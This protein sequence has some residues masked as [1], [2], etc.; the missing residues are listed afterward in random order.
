M[1]K[2]RMT[3][4]GHAIWMSV[5]GIWFAVAYNSLLLSFFGG[6]LIGYGL[7]LAYEAGQES[8]L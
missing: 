4:Y 2:V 8:K 5:F 3:K 7:K 1:G 6:V